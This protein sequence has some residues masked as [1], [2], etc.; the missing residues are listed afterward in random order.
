MNKSV[1]WYLVIL[2]V[3]GLAPL[4]AEGPKAVATAP[5]AAVE[6]EGVLEES[7]EELTEDLDEWVFE[8]LDAAGE[9]VEEAAG[10]E[11]PAQK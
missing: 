8:E 10:E 4:Y 2:M 7:E 5:V 6:E 1:F 3:F 11:K 9:P